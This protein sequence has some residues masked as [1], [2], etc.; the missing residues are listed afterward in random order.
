MATTFI[1]VL[2]ALIGCGGNSKST[3]ISTL[4]APKFHTNGVTTPRDIIVGPDGNLWFTEP[5]QS[6][7]G[8]IG[9]MTPDGTPLDVNVPSGL[10][11]HPSA[12]TNGPDNSVWV[13]G[14]GKIGHDAT[15]DRIAVSG[16]GPTATLA[17][18]AITAANGLPADASISAI[19]L[20]PDGNLYFANANR[21]WIGQ[22][23]LHNGTN[24]TVNKLPGPGGF[25][26][27]AGPDGNL[28]IGSDG[29]QAVTTSGTPVSGESFA[30]AAQTGADYGSSVFGVTLGPDGKDLW[31]TN[32]QSSSKAGTKYYIGHI[33]FDA[34]MHASL[35]AEYPV[36]SANDTGRYTGC[37]LCRIT[38]GPDGNLWYA[39]PADDSIGRISTTGAP[40]DKVA[41]PTAHSYPFGITSGPNNTMYFTENQ[42]PGAIG[43]VQ[44]TIKLVPS[45]YT[46]VSSNLVQVGVNERATVSV[47]CPSDTQMLGGGY[48]SV[49]KDIS[50][51]LVEEN[52]PSDNH[53][54]TVTVLNEGGPHAFY[55]F[56]YANCLNN[57]P[58]VD[59][60][61]VS[62]AA[63]TIALEQPNVP[64]PTPVP[65][66]CPDGYVVTGGGFQMGK[67][68]LGVGG[69][70]AITES[71]AVIASSRMLW[72]VAAYA[73]WHE[74][75]LTAYAVCASSHNTYEPPTSSTPE[76]GTMGTAGNGAYTATL[77]AA[78]TSGLLT[79]GS[80]AWTGPEPQLESSSY[81][82]TLP[83]LDIP[84]NGTNGP[85]SQWNTRNGDWTV[86]SV[87]RSRS[88]SATMT[89]TPVCWG[90]RGSS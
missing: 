9:R 25:A 22:V 68:D 75:S 38:A 21:G 48:W 35:A 44:V 63:T 73:P 39:N 50:Y 45:I 82:Q 77:Y 8:T 40:Q 84:L 27:T 52:Y 90:F 89:L 34:Q 18:T 29:V 70:L 79:Q 12:L 71:Q 14:P 10:A 72:E 17:Y 26:I 81:P 28:W 11:W 60:R 59:Q 47:T 83:S 53:T 43:A 62:S 16:Q 19:T 4:S 61:I 51:T 56:A 32:V 42:P 3:T 49:G 6:G 85:G 5:Q 88:G 33:T 36:A 76:S 87:N 46:A 1:V 20:G 67:G 64:S 58:S 24:Y 30:T 41:I 15:L 65:A 80:M 23:D 54:W 66:D 31:F 69:F 55:L 7:G 37:D 74:A 86:V 2:S 78:C 57:G 13:A